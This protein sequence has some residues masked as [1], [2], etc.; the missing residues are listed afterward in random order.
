MLVNGSV[1]VVPRTSFL[2]TA[3]GLEIAVH[4]MLQ[5]MALLRTYSY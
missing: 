4:G 1:F 3:L 5:Y 2:P